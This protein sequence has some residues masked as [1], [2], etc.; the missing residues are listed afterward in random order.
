MIDNFFGDA[1]TSQEL[2]H[3]VAEV[4]AV[5]VKKMIAFGRIFLTNVL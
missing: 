3:L 1:I 2:T 4:I 5:L